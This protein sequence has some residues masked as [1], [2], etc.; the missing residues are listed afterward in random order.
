MAITDTAALDLQFD[1]SRIVEL[2]TEDGTDLS[3]TILAELIAVIDGMIY[4][5]LAKQ[6]TT[7]QIDADAG[8]RRIGCVLVMEALE[9]RRGSATAD[10]KRMADEA[11]MILETY[12]TNEVTPT[13][14]TQVLPT[15]IDGPS[16]VFS[17]SEYFDGM[18]DLTDV[19]DN[20]PS[21]GFGSR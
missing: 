7:T 6:L 11:R 5:K 14:V 19:S 17:Q 21:G 2:C 18:P 8:L 13:A 4:N 9:L 1:Q 16:E 10:V 3:S 20:A 12:A 15:S